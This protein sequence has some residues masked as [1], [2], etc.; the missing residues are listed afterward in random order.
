MATR[1]IVAA[2]LDLSEDQKAALAKALADCKAR[3]DHGRDAEQHLATQ[4]MATLSEGQKQ[5]WERMLGRPF[6]PRATSSAAR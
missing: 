3:R 5:R 4:V 6:H 2:A 1:P